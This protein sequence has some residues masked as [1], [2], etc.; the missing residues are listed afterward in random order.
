MNAQRAYL[1]LQYN[2]VATMPSFTGSSRR[3]RSTS[4]LTAGVQRP[5][6]TSCKVRT[7][8]RLFWKAGGQHDR[9][10]N[11][12]SWQLHREGQEAQAQSPGGRHASAGGLQTCSAS[13]RRPQTADLGSGRAARVQGIQSRRNYNTNVAAP[14][15]AS[16]VPYHVS[17]ALVGAWER[18]GDAAHG[19][20]IVTWNLASN[21]T[22]LR[23]VAHH[24]ELY[25]RT[26]TPSTVL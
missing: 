15:Q 4:C 14:F 13:S 21:G 7:K 18:E 1:F 26:H 17:V 3:Q 10:T 22:K 25:L 23:K 11:K 2:R 8:P 5:W 16:N 19:L 20:G 6:R 9:D 24:D 12:V